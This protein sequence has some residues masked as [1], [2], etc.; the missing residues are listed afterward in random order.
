MP[1]VV[2]IF[3]GGDIWFKNFLVYK[4]ELDKADKNSWIAI[5]SAAHLPVLLS[6][7]H[8]YSSSQSFLQILSAMP[9]H[10]FSN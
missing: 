1:L 9:L 5:P 3:V 10:H 7:T 6:C 2:F 4:G 8:C